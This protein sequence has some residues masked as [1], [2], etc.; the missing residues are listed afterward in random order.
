MYSALYYMIV[1]SVPCFGTENRPPGQGSERQALDIALQLSSCWVITGFLLSGQPFCR[2]AV[3]ALGNF[4][5]L[6]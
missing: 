2:C 4:Q 3:A 6:T 1:P 5:S